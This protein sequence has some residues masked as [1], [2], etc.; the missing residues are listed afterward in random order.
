M[1][2]QHN[3]FQHDAFQWMPDG[4]A[5]GNVP[6]GRGALVTAAIIAAAWIPAQFSAVKY[7]VATQDNTP[8][9][10]HV[11]PLPDQQ[12]ARNAAWRVTWGAQSRPKS[13]TLHAAAAVDQPPR[14]ST[15][16]IQRNP[17]PWAVKWGAQSRG[18]LP[19]LDVVAAVNDP[20]FRLQTFPAAI[21]AWQPPSFGVVKFSVATEDGVTPPVTGDD[22]PPRRLEVPAAVKAWQPRAFS[23]YGSSVYT[24]VQVDNPPPYRPVPTTQIRAWQVT[25]GAQKSQQGLPWTYVPPAVDV[26]PPKQE[27]A[28]RTVWQYWYA[29]S[30]W[31]VDPRRA[32]VVTESGAVVPPVV[33]VP[34]SGGSAKRIRYRQKQ[35]VEIDG[36]YFEVRSQREALDILKKLRDLAK[37]TAPVVA[38]EAGE[39]PVIAPVVTIRKPDYSQA[40][41]QALQEQVDATN[42]AIAETYRLALESHI[43]WQ[44]GLAQ[45]V[46]ERHRLEAEKRQREDDDD[47]DALIALGIL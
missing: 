10:E 36:E 18:E 26:P 1:S 22:P 33:D 40:Y 45:Q 6:V 21:A 13:A 46:M 8:V 12:V 19:P 43:A 44:L 11:A 7:S 23:S 5:A 38:V 34:P 9:V 3:A 31:K 25:W 27:Y 14:Y 15:A 41:V 4:S 20:P 16:Q 17:L 47:I 29:A 42:A 37:E 24:H 30:Q 2:F 39:A 32:P 28:A 35:Y